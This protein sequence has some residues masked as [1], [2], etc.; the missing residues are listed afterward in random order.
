[1]RKIVALLLLSLCWVACSEEQSPEE[2]ALAAAK[3]AAAQYYNYLLAGKYEQFLDARVGADSLPADYRAQLIAS[4]KQ[5]IAMQ[6]EHEGIA[7]FEVS[8][9]RIDSTSHLI[10]V[11]L[12]LRYGN[13]EQEEIVVPMVEYNGEWRMK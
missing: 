6:K 1:M 9:A 13:N 2:K 7:S 3:E 10:Q 12:A 5:Y 8:N 4:Y 11:F